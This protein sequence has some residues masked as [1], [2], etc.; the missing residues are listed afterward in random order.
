M[1]EDFTPNFGDKR[2]GCCITTTHCLT[3]PFSPGKFDQKQQ[4]CHHP[5]MQWIKKVVVTVLYMVKGK[6][7]KAIPVSFHGDP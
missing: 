2:T 7:G 6:K 4:D 5:P 3:L 1:C